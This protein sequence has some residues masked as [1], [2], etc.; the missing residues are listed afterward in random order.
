MDAAVHYKR[1]WHKRTSGDAFIGGVDL[2]FYTIYS[3]ANPTVRLQGR[4]AEGPVGTLTIIPRNDPT[5]PELES[6]FSVFDM[7]PINP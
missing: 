2:N 3:G 5:Y 6:I 4:Q 7:G 1:T